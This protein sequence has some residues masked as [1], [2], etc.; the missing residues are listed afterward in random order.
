[1]FDRPKSRKPVVKEQM[2]GRFPDRE[3]KEN[4]VQSLRTRE[5]PSADVEQGHLSALM[6]HYANISYRTGHKLTID[7][8]TE[9]IVDDAEARK[10]F[11]RTYREPYVI[12][13]EV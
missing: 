4:F 5:L 10:L 7:P 9:E 11:K 12:A 1:M 8:K 2:Y 3:H 6:I 13:E